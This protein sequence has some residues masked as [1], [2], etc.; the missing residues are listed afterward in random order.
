MKPNILCKTPKNA[1]TYRDGIQT[2][3]VCV[4]MVDYK[5]L[6]LCVIIFFSFRIKPAYTTTNYYLVLSPHHCFL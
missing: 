5:P 3:I 1:Y 4:I 2:I 6:L